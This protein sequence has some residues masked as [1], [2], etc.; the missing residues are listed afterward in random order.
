M[1]GVVALAPVTALGAVDRPV[2][3]AAE[4]AQVDDDAGG[5]AAGD[6]QEVP[7]LGG[8][9]A[10]T[11]PGAAGELPF[12][13]L[14]LLPIVMLVVLLVFA[15]LAFRRRVPESGTSSTAE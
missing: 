1:L 9:G 8:G 5:G 11:E 2:A 3:T 6:E 15:G 13:G 4:L 14:M 10:D 12:T 7:G